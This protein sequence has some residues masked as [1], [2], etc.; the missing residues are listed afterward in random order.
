MT[1]PLKGHQLVSVSGEGALVLVAR[2]LVSVDRVVMLVVLKVATVAANDVEVTVA[3]S[4][5]TEVVLVE[6]QR[7][8]MWRKRSTDPFMSE[9]LVT[10]I[11]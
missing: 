6:G 10:S 1:I 11:L 5:M 4:S 3:V 2:L 9:N 8:R 7:R